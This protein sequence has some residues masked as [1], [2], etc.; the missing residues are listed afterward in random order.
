MKYIVLSVIVFVSLKAI[1]Q[2]YY[3]YKNEKI[4]L[5]KLPEKRFILI[6]DNTN[7]KLFKNTLNAHNIEASNFNI[8]NVNIGLNKVSNEYKKERK[9]SVISTTDVSRFSKFN[10][11]N[12]LYESDFYLTKSGIEV[13]LSHLFYVKLNDVADTVLLFE[14][15]TKN[16]VDVLGNHTYRPLWYTL[17]CSNKSKGDALEMANLF[18]ETTYFAASEPDLM[19]DDTPNCTNDTHFNNQWGL[20][21]AGQHGGTNGVDINLCQASLI[22]TGNENITVAVLDH[23]FEMNHPDL[24]NV[25]PQSFDTESGTSPAKILGK[26]GTACA[27]IIGANSN[28]STGIAGIAPNCPLMSISNSLSATPDSRKK[29]ADGIDFAVQH[30]ASV[31]SNSWSSATEYQVI[32]D[33]I[34][35]ALNNGR[36]G[37][38][39]VVVFSAGNDNGNISYPA[40]T[41]WSVLVVGALSPCGERKNPGSCDGENWGSNYSVL[42]NLL[43]VMAPGVLIPTTDRQGSNGYNKSSGTSGDYYQSFNGTSSA[44][45]HVA[46]IA[47]LVLSVNSGLHGGEVHNIIARTADKVRSDIYN[48]ENHGLL[49][50]WNKEVGY[51]LANAEA[52]LEEAICN[53][54]IRNTTYTE[55]T[56]ISGCDNVNMRNITVSNGATLSVTDFNDLSIV[57]GFSAELGTVLNF[58]P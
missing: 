21:N 23:G 31:I 49:D 54:Q 52:A 51:G 56:T 46:G 36:N 17:S 42:G 14:L 11:E 19:S 33:A 3:W 2:D 1:G 44:C 20:N 37:L 38:G 13:G 15:A 50:T 53:N 22:T 41:F 47:A 7:E 58:Q 27:G 8:T 12:I 24:A 10:R 45:P 28:N 16:N 18:Y 55:N 48:Y 39:C 25:H 57:H 9:W 29:R 30:G 35:N 6:D 4:T 5:K 43:D 34:L 32:D 26:H 40:N